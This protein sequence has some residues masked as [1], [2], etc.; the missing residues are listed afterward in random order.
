[1]VG[2]D[3]IVA[4]EGIRSPADLRG[5]RIAIQAYGPHVDFVGRVLA[6]A[7]LSFDDVTVVWAR[8]LTGDGNTPAGL[9]ADGEADA[10]AV[11]L[12]DARL[13]TSGGRSAPA[14]RVR[15]GARPS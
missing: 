4:A 14:L 11:I 15:C 3:G 6:D 1:M 13:L 12:P 2:G 10:A 9:L 5:K 8:D 7:G